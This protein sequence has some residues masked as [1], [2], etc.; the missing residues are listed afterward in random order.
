MQK[1]FINMLT[2]ALS[3]LPVLRHINLVDTL[4]SFFCKIHFNVI[5][6]SSPQATKWFLWSFPT[7]TLCTFFFTQHHFDARSDLLYT[8]VKLENFVSMNQMHM[9]GTT[10]LLHLSINLFINVSLCC[11]LLPLNLPTSCQVLPSGF[12]LTE[13]CMNCSFKQ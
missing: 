13:F 5:F 11:F 4:T 7:E 1:C 12:Y 6:S 8:G 2:A 10:E 9:L 3:L